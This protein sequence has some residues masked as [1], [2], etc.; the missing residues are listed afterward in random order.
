LRDAEKM[1]GECRGEGENKEEK[2]EVEML[3]A[4]EI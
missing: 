2:R 4:L 1:E 3:G